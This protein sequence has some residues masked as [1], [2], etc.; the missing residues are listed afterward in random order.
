M[1]DDIELEIPANAAEQEFGVDDS[2]AVGMEDQDMEEGELSDND[3]HISSSN[4]R[5]SLLDRIGPKSK[6]IH[7]RLGPR[8]VNFGKSLP[9]LVQSLGGSGVSSQDPDFAQKKEARAKRFQLSN[10]IPEPSFDDVQGMYES[11]EVP[12]DQLEK[13]AIERDFRFETIHITGFSTKITTDDLGEYFK[14]FNPISCEWCDGKSAN[15]VWALDGSAA[16]AMCYLSR[17][18]GQAESM[19]NDAPN[20]GADENLNSKFESTSFNDPIDPKLLGLEISQ[21]ANGPWRLGK[22]SSLANWQDSPVIFMRLSR[23]TDVQPALQ[24]RDLSKKNFELRREGGILSRSKKERIKEAMMHD[25]RMHEEHE[26]SKK[27]APGPVPWAEMA[28]N[29]TG[30]KKQESDF[31]DE[32]ANLAAMMQRRG[33]NVAMPAAQQVTAAVPDS[34]KHRLSLPSR[35]TNPDWD[36]PANDENQAPVSR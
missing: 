13:A 4:I 30:A 21:P 11:L 27:Y 32:L 14:D 35:R 17:P 12:K 36:N 3:Q 20:V 25:Q 16:K 29:W 26:R 7:D 34:M 8:V 23:K 15:I 9:D 5:R 24:D 2:K 6:N 28:E 1:D 22:P 18:L 19:E 31:S 33:K 10:T